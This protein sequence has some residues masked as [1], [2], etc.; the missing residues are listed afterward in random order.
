MK[1]VYLSLL[2]LVACITFS[3]Q[4]GKKAF[5]RGDYR[6]A[7]LQALNRLKS[8][9][10]NEKATEILQ[11]GYPLF[12]DYYLDQIEFA[13]M[14]TD[15]LKW[16]KVYRCYGILNDVY[17]E[18]A[19]T[20]A[21]LEMIPQARN[22]YNEY[23]AARDQLAIARYE[24]G[25]EALDTGTRSDAIEAYRH[26]ERV[27]ELNSTYRDIDDRIVQARANATLWVEIAPIPTVSKRFELSSEFFEQEVL[28]FIQNERISPFVQFIPE[29]SSAYGST[30][31][32]HRLRF[33]FEDFIV[34]QTYEREIQVG[35]EKEGIEI[36]TTQIE[37]STHT[38]YGTVAASLYGFE[39]EIV[40]NG[41]LS[42]ELVDVRD[43][44]VLLTRSFSGTHVW[45]DYWGYVEGDKRA[46]DETDEKYI[47]K[48][49]PAIVPDPQTLFVEFT[50]PIYDQV[51][52]FVE[53]Y[54]EA[55]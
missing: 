45:Y 7:M 13:K 6:L 47:A 52:Q 21:A 33:T 10:E 14:D 50:R 16:E 9:P 11:R 27:K 35:R 38:V 46:L 18:M 17:D 49:R 36:G 51:T 32:H 22:F 12:Q 54:Y 30:P 23:V 25:L 19:R 31:P 29:G 8:A 2:F 37:D 5:E 24:L 53:S 44:T 41:I 40:S 48:R 3:C 55:Y 26:F 42:V 15:P 28:N 4:T 43:N 34:G 39:R 1:N 20:P